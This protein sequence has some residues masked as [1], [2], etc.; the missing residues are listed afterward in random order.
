M[1]LK[2]MFKAF[3]REWRR[4]WRGRLC[5]ECGRKYLRPRAHRCSKKADRAEMI[6]H[7]EAASIVDDR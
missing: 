3:R 1:G 2:A 5:Q 6:A 7:L 4:D